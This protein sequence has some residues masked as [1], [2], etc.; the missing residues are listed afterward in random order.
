MSKKLEQYNKSWNDVYYRLVFI[1]HLR[2]NINRI[3][4]EDSDLSSYGSVMVVAGSIEAI[5]LNIRLITE[6]MVASAYRYIYGAS[7]KVPSRSNAGKELKKLGVEWRSRNVRGAARNEEGVFQA[8]HTQIEGL[9]VDDLTK[10]KVPELDGLLHTPPELSGHDYV[11][12]L[13]RCS[14]IE[15]R[16]LDLLSGVVLYKE[17]EGI[18]REGILMW[19]WEDGKGHTFP[20]TKLP[21]GA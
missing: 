20:L 12:C 8:G 16:L 6:G 21:G 3:L 13:I 4:R 2:E 1:K 14:D 5:A 10:G 17:G 19:Y 15:H 7:R 9:S 11:D 18:H